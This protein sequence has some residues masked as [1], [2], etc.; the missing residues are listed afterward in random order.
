MIRQHDSAGA[1]ANGTGAA[2]DIADDHRRGGTGDADHVVVLRQPE[3]AIAPALSVLCEIKRM[4]QRVRRRGSL[5]NECEIENG[6]RAQCASLCGVS[7]ILMLARA[8]SVHDWLIN[9]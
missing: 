9:S 5:G 7:W 4:V 8:V 3:A 2:G 1:N 6:E